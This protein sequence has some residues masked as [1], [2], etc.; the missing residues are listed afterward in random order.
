MSYDERT[1]KLLMLPNSTGRLVSL[2]QDMSKLLRLLNFWIAGGMDVRL[3]LASLSS[4]R[5]INSNTLE[6][7]L[8]MWVCIELEFTV[9]KFWFSKFNRFGCLG[10]FLSINRTASPSFI[11]T[12]RPCSGH[13]YST[14]RTNLGWVR[15]A[16][17]G[18]QALVS[19]FHSCIGVLWMLQRIKK[20]NDLM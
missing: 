9:S 12:S 19:C 15:A 5:E 13:Y 10:R 2:L 3:L 7:I 11:S 1:C 8:I 20:H 18:T 4:V 14:R 16:G 17:S 6:G